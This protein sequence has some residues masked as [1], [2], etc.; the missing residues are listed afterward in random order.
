M[1][2]ASIRY[3]DREEARRDR[4]KASPSRKHDARQGM[5]RE[6]RIAHREE[7]IG[8]LRSMSAGSGP[9][10]SHTRE[11]MRKQVES[12]HKELKERS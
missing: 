2:R 5:F 10:D 1:S 4:D 9:R 8:R 6:G 7:M 11:A 3:T 12:Y